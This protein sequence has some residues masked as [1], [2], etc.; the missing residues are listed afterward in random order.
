MLIF[1][2][3]VLF[4]EFSIKATKKFHES[5]LISILKCSMRFFESTPIGRIINRFSKDIE[6]AE[7]RI[8]DAFKSVT[9]NMFNFMSV[10]LV[11]SITIPAFLIALVPIAVLYYFIQ[12]C[13]FKLGF[14]I[15]FIIN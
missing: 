6:V 12:V 8:P 9:R 2:S 15:L 10:I 3:D 5:M 4:V 7:N 11:L 1:I 14:E 13:F